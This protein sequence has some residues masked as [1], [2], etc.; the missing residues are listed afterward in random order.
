MFSIITH[1]IYLHRDISSGEAWTPKY[2]TV[3]H[4]LSKTQVLHETLGQE[5]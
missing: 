1:I 4:K 5:R 3:S 2:T